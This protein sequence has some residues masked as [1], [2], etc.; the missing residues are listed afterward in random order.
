[1]WPVRRR[2]RLGVH[3]SQVNQVAATALAGFGGGI[4]AVIY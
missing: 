2:G 4:R 1:M 3:G